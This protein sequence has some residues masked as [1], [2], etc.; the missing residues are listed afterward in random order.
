MLVKSRFVVLPTPARTPIFG[1]GLA[2]FVK[3][4]PLRFAWC[5]VRQETTVNASAIFDAHS[6][7]RIPH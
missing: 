1:A 3:E 5:V 6:T 2:V 7:I 4:L